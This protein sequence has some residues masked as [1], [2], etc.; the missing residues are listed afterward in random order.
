MFS[1]LEAPLFIREAIEQ[2]KPRALW[3]ELIIFGLVFWIAGMVESIIIVPFTVIAMLGHTEELQALLNGGDMGSDAML[4][5]VEKLYGSPVLIIG[6]LF[7]TAG[8]IATVIVYCRFLEK[9]RLSTL[10]LSRPFAKE[11]GIGAILGLLLF[12]VYLVFSMVFGK[13]T[14]LG[15]SESF[16]LPTVLFLLLGYLVQGFSE[17]IL[18]RGYFMTSLCR[19]LPLPVA[20]VISS[21]FFSLLH[22]GNPGVDFLALLN[23]FLFGIL[24]GL[25]VIR[26]GSL[27]G[28]CALHALW[29][30]AEGVLTDFTVS[31]LTMPSSVFSFGTEGAS[32]F[33]IGG[34]FGP[35]GGFA[36]TF[37]LTI[38]VAILLMTPNKNANNSLQS[39]TL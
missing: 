10:G 18:C 4:A 1:R 2:K 19:T 36:V 29:N 9:R 13:I 32:S 7:A 39:D 28:A 8:M 23:I 12:G 15:I 11:Y 20:L 6:S 26:R 25:Y 22:L 35:E 30:F 34:A 38:T 14:F 24:M 5:F 17:E 16:N 33:I 3:L 21:L 27:W 37:V 31:G